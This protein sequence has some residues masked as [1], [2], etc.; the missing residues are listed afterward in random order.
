MNN[1]LI[2]LAQTRMGATLEIIFMLLGAGII[3]YIVSWLYYKSIYEKRIKVIEIERGRLKNQ[4]VNLTDDKN[5]LLK[6]VNEKDKTIEHL[7]FEVKDAKALVYI[8]KRR[9]LLNYDSFGTALE[10]ENEDLQM[11]S[12]IGPLIEER[13]YA[14]DIYT[15]RQISRFTPQDIEIIND[16]ILYFYGRIERDEWVAQAK[17]LVNDERLKAALFKRIS[18]RKKSFSYK[19]IGVARKE[20][21]DD[22]T[23]IS[24]IG[25]WI[26]E[27]LFA[28]DIFTFLQISKFDKEDINSVTEAIEYFPGRIERDE[29]VYQAQELVRI[30]GNKSELL[31]RIQA[32]QGRIYFDRLGIAHKHEANNLTR[33]DGLGLWVE[34]R[35]NMLGIYTFD[36]ISKLTH[37]DIETI[38]EVLEIIPG[39]IEQDNWV[40]QARKLSIN[41][42]HEVVS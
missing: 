40:D 39:R 9:H 33:I 26:K 18:D 41:R 21:A 29:W 30:A 14:L 15:Y 32:R 36:Q 13:L 10:E 20:Q 38:T 2:L 8:S 25:G 19:R 23:R 31:K 22:L 35:L 17:E 24:G 37:A 7:E 16:A 28:L 12:G 5:K 34:E 1:L 3:C 6:S 27:K 42:T 11:I 4:I